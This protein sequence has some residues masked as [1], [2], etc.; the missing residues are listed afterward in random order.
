MARWTALLL[1]CLLLAGTHWAAADDDEPEEE[2]PVLVSAGA[3]GH[4]RAHWEPCSDAYSPLLQAGVAVLVKSPAASS[5]HSASAV[6]AAHR[7]PSPPLA[8]RSP[9]AAW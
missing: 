5:R 3:R 1:G 9:A 6:A 8:R 2:G 7:L 4:D